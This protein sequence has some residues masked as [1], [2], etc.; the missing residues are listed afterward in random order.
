MTV[1]MCGLVPART[2]SCALSNVY[3]IWLGATYNLCIIKDK[4][5]KLQSKTEFSFLE[6]KHSA[7]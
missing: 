7:A 6:S 1:Y 5:V 3:Q 2:G 4:T